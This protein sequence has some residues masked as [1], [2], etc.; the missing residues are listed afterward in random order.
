MKRI[1]AGLSLLTLSC[2]GPSSDGKD[3]VPAGLAAA[4][5]TLSA[6]CP[7]LTED[8]GGRIVLSYVGEENDSVSIM[9]YA[10]SEDGGRTFGAPVGIPPSAGVQPHGENLP[11]MV[12]KPDGEIIAVWGMGN[13]SPKRKYAGLVYYALSH[14]GGRT[15]GEA[16]PL[17]RD[18]ASVDQR[19]FDVAVLPGGEAGILWLDNRKTSAKEGST[20]YF[21]ATEGRNGFGEGRPLQEGICQCCR[22]ELFVDGEGRVHAAYRA[23]LNDSI[24]DM[25]HRVSTDGGKT[26][27]PPRRISPDQWVIRGCPHTGPAMAANR[28][29]LHFAWYT[30]G[31]GEGVFYGRSEDGGLNYSP[32]ESVSGKASAKHPQIAAFPD[33]NLAIVW[34]EFS[35]ED[36]EDGKGKAGSSVIAGGSRV[37]LQLRDP[38]GKLLA[39]MHVSGEEEDASFPVLKAVDD[40][41]V[42]I[43]YTDAAGGS[44]RV[45]YRTRSRVR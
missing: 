35:G 31:G 34:D 17:V 3:G 2:G 27:S 10:V 26:F 22:T 12:F 14:D 40:T 9:R 18:T 6:S 25:V 15:F 30:L 32:R 13:P 1:L 43:A 33:G 45:R 41:T 8:G 19:Y 20:L 36:G 29:G 21:A 37:R 23:I 44:S 5:D 11:K 28:N 24:R 4:I 38:A 39:G 7:F 16:R 42:L